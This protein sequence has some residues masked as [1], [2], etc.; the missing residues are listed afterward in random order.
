M[1]VASGNFEYFKNNKGHGEQYLISF[2]ELF[3]IFSSQEIQ[4]DNKK[5]FSCS[6]GFP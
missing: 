3:L 2:H 4:E 1:V 6:L 5:Q